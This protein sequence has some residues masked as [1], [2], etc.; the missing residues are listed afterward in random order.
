[1]IDDEFIRQ[2]E[3]SLQRRLSD[4]EETEAQNERDRAPVELDQTRVGR[5]S[6]VDAVQGQAMAEAQQERRRIER[7]RIETALARIDDG[8]YGECLRCG[9]EIAEKRLAADPATPV[10]VDCA[11]NP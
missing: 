7:L 2:M 8:T 1:M 4:L 5:L 10:C 11:G 6:R 9:D 3:Q